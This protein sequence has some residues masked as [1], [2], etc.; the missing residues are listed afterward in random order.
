[1]ARNKPKPDKTTL[2]EMDREAAEYDINMA[3]DRILNRA[4]RLRKLIRLHAPDAIINNEIKMLAYA[5]L[6]VGQM[7]DNLELLKQAKKASGEKT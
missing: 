5:P 3:I 4:E 7:L 2:V 1:M 6:V